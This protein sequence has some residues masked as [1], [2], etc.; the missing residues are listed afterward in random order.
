MHVAMKFLTYCC[1]SL[2][3]IGTMAGSSLASGPVDVV[4]LPVFS[5]GT[6]SYPLPLRISLLNSGGDEASGVVN[7]GSSFQQIAYPFQLKPKEQ[8]SFLAYCPIY[9]EDDTKQGEVKPADQIPD[10]KVD[11]S[12][13]A[14]SPRLGQSASSQTLTFSHGNVRVLLISQ[15]ATKLEFLAKYTGYQKS[16]ASSKSQTVSPVVSGRLSP[17]FALDRSSAYL[18]FEEIIL[19]TGTQ[20]LSDSQIEA[21]KEYVVAGGR[22]IFTPT[23]ASALTDPRW[24]GL[25][26]AKSGTRYLGLGSLVNLSFDP[27]K[28]ESDDE[29]LR[30]RF[31]K[32]ALANRDNVTP[33]GLLN[34]AQN[35]GSGPGVGADG[36]NPFLLQIPS[37][38]SVVGVLFGYFV[39]VI[40]LNI[41][42]LRKLNRPELMWITAPLLAFGFAGFIFKSSSRLS[43][44]PA[45]I[46]AT[47]SLITT[48]DIKR[49]IIHNSFKLFSPKAGTFGF[50]LNDAVELGRQDLPFEGRELSSPPEVDTGFIDV[51]AY[52]SSNLEFRN[53]VDVEEPPTDPYVQFSV[54]S[55]E[56][57]IYPIIATNVGKTTITD[58]TF[59]AGLYKTSDRT[60]EP[61][62]SIKLMLDHATPAPLGEYTQLTK[63]LA[64]NSGGLA[65][66]KK[67]AMLAQV[68]GQVA[69]FGG[70]SDVPVGPHLEQKNR[71]HSQV[72]IAAF[73]PVNMKLP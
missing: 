47:A 4:A 49:E 54:G 28:V 53:F 39:L 22:L 14:N 72:L 23:S 56:N 73:A 32:E 31:D 45:T 48:P 16:V 10:W 2:V 68:H 50:H 33:S 70:L 42:V 67:A 17:K 41:L 8:K 15:T 35:F 66:L 46:S 5:Q 40:P 71:F 65:N 21:L 61:G 37:F 36:Q 26:A 6:V 55:P 20:E 7:V 1:L 64:Q 69:L 58:A 44:S 57:S 9:T 52:H 63:D 30:V 38:G 27:E 19:G 43:D 29:D 60:L 51:P 25:V 3:A 59:V 34:D 62:K 11:V 18:R 24:A 13:K 12:M